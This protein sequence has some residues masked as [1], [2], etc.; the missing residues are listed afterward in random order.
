M[1]ASYYYGNSSNVEQF[2]SADIHDWSEPMINTLPS[3]NIFAILWGGGS[4]TSVSPIS[5]NSGD[6]DWM[7]DKIEQ[8]SHDPVK[9]DGT[10]G[11]DGGDGGDGVMAVMAVMAVII[12][13]QK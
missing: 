11:G 10:G 2:L 5:T 6:G 7:A 3:H 12:F 8:Y 1:D 13:P 4:T 9:L